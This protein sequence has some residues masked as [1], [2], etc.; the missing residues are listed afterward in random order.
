MR[1]Y[2]L[3]LFQS[4]KKWDPDDSYLV[5]MVKDCHRLTSAFKSTSLSFVH[6]SVMDLLA[7]NVA[8]YL[9]IGG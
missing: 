5:M 7:Q 6:K 1:T 3:P 4:W 2:Y 8:T 9:D